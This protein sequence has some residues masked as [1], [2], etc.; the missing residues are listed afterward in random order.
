[1]TLSHVSDDLVFKTWWD[2]CTDDGNVRLGDNT[3]TFQNATKK[4]GKT[5]VCLIY[6]LTCLGYFNTSPQ[7]GWL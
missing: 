2:F 4:I 6:T 1:M 3:L 7:Y 5:A